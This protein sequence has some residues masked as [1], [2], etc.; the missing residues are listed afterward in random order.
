MYI[1]MAL[2]VLAGVGI[3]LLVSFLQ[4]RKR[5]PEFRPQRRAEPQTSWQVLVNL[6]AWGVLGVL[7]VRWLAR[8]GAE[9]LQWWERWSH[10]LESAPELLSASARALLQQVDSPTAGYALFA[11]VLL[12]Y[13]GL[14]V[15]GLW[16]LFTD[17]E[18]SGALAMLENPQA[19]QVQRAVRAGLRALQQHTEPRQAIIACYAQL[20]HL[21]EDH[22]VPA[23]QQLT[24]QECMGA[25]L[26]GIALPVEAFA[27]LVNLFEQAR[28][29]LH[30]LD[31]TARMQA[32]AHLTTIQDALAE[33]APLASHP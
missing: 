17:R 5:P 28:Y 6:L 7:G 11:V 26:Q 27:A 14:T 19:Q 10:E 2:V 8:H 23:I 32:M 33:E 30:P 22:G 31:H 16:I 13:G 18:Q 4:R 29:S 15:L 9:L 21:L 12:I 24:P 25:A 20:E 3:T 1:M